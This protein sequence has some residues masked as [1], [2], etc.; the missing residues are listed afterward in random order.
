MTQEMLLELTGMQQLGEG[1][2]LRAVGSILG[3]PVTATAAKNG[4]T[5][6]LEFTSP[7]KNSKVNK[8]RKRLLEDK[9]L[10]GKVTT[11]INA[12]RP[13]VFSVI[14]T[15]SDE[16]DAQAIYPYIINRLGEVLQEFPELAPPT[17]C[18][19]CNN[20]GSDTLA[21]ID[22]AL[23]FVHRN[24]LEQLVQ[25]EKQNFEDKEDRPNTFRGLIGS[26]LGGVVGA[27]P[28]LLVLYF[29]E[30][31]VFILFAII[32]VGAAFGWRLFG[33]KF[34]RLTTVFVILLTLVL[35]VFVDVFNTFLILREV[36]GDFITLGD[37]IQF[38]YLDM[39]AFVEWELYRNTLLS[40]LG[41]AI[42]LFVSWRFITKTDSDN[43]S[44]AQSVLDEA[45]PLTTN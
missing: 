36:F 21:T 39:Y 11:L 25:E 3:Y 19:I 43:L 40:L 41:A 29:F 15:P 31:F 20:I 4:K 18:A 34:S 2:T 30:Y 1:K 23:T 22:G 17:L 32:P 8:L 42:G 37:T 24:C 10:K 35:S 26:V 33:G 27:L 38:A 5:L 44:E 7:G 9:S 16:A 28:A 13:S 45:V 6:T 14:I 12:E